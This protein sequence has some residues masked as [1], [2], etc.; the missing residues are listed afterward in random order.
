MSQSQTFSNQNGGN[1]NYAAQFPALGPPSQSQPTAANTPNNGRPSNAQSSNGKRDYVAPQYPTLKPVQQNNQPAGGNGQASTNNQNGGRPSYASQFPSLGPQPQSPTTSVTPA[2]Q[3]NPQ[4][5]NGKRDYVAPQYTT[6]K[7]NQPNNQQAGGK[8]KD[9]IQFY[10]SKTPTQGTF[11]YSSVLQGNTNKN[12]QT[13][14]PTSVQTPKP[15][16]TAAWGNRP[17]TLST[18]TTPKPT[19]RLPSTPMN[20]PGTPTTRPGTPVLPSSIVNNNHGTAN[21]NT[22]TDAELEALSEELLRKD[23][24]N[25]A[26]YITI[27]YQ[28]KTTSHST[29]D[30]A[31]LP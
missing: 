4:T 21:S 30:L 9:L 8:V 27:N 1:T 31:P 17:S 26:R 16:S 2:P 3:R 12:G 23:V 28:A 11:S 19:T 29:A 24:N 5:P 13:A 14:P 20:R 25:A 15:M 18:V 7:P 10:D 22:V 6:V